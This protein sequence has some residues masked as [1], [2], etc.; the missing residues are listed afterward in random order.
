[1]IID[2]HTHTPTHPEAVP[3][4]RLI[5]NK[6]WRPDRPVISTFSY[7]DHLDAMAPVDHALVFGIAPIPGERTP[8]WTGLPWDPDVNIN[9]LTAAFVKTRPDKLSGFVSVHPFAHDA[10]D[11][12][13]RGIHHLGFKGIKLGPN[14][15][16]FDPLGPEARAV[17]ARAQSL[18]VPILFHQGTSPVRGAPIRF[19]HP[20]LMDEIAIAYPELRI[21]MAH[22]GHPWQADTIAVIRK[23]P[24]V[25]ADVSAQFYRPGSFYNAMLLATEWNVLHK[26]VLGSDYP[27]TTPQET[28]DGMRRVNAPARAA[29]LPLVPEDAIEAIIRRDSLSLLGIKP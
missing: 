6:A 26:L 28:I 19:A 18:A 13:D 17:Y 8:G 3:R 4:D 10:L 22:I 9:D 12:I 25:Y 15:Q 7:A 27:I 21:V 20:L 23:H 2:V 29:N 16:N 11:E 24:H 1:V 14:Y 5:V